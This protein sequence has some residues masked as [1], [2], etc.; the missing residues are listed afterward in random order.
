L[1]LNQKILTS[2]ISPN[3]YAKDYKLLSKAKIYN[4][5]DTTTLQSLIFLFQD[6]EK[7]LSIFRSMIF[8]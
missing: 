6:T 2:N 1:S 5:G 4:F 8:L 3:M 7:A